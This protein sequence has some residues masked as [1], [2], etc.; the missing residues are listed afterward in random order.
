ML[1]DKLMSNIF[2]N[3]SDYRIAPDKSFSMRDYHKVNQNGVRVYPVTW[4]VYSPI[5]RVAGFPTEELAKKFVERRVNPVEIP[6]VVYSDICRCGIGVINWQ[7]VKVGDLVFERCL[8]CRNPM[9]H[10]VMTELNRPLIEDFDLEA[11][12]GL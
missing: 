5:N 7:Y 11:F 10:N 9:R 3:E 6:A 12:L 4:Y 1:I 2:T 8:N